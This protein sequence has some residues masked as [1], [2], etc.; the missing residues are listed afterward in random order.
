MAFF[1]GGQ[2]EM[3]ELKKTGLLGLCN[4]SFYFS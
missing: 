4:I 3:R 1:G 2:L